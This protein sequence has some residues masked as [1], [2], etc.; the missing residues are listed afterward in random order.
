[1]PRV[2]DVLGC[3]AEIASNKAVRT[4]AVAALVGFCNSKRECASL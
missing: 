4:E 2:I 3:E 1:V